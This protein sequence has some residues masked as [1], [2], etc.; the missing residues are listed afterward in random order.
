MTP[1]NICVLLLLLFGVYVCVFP[2]AGVLSRNL[3]LSRWKSQTAVPVT[4][5]KSTQV[6]LSCFFKLVF[7]CFPMNHL[8]VYQRFELSSN[9]KLK[10]SYYDS[11]FS[12]I[13][14]TPP[15]FSSSFC[16]PKAPHL[17]H[18]RE[19]HSYFMSALQKPRHTWE[20]RPSCKKMPPS[21]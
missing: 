6:R 17:V 16:C 7:S 11:L 12:R 2:A 20:N 8:E 10:G 13:P 1:R 15:Q 4:D 18:L 19:C 9:T 3:N 21:D 5:G 14:P